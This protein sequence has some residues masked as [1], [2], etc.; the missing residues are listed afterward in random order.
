MPP[1]P[2]SRAGRREWWVM[3]PLAVPCRGRLEAQSSLYAR[4]QSDGLA[5]DRFLLR[6]VPV[7]QVSARHETR[8][9]E[10]T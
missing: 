9:G 2:G 8:T 10:P 6:R 7:I 1:R 5:P 3:A 4:R